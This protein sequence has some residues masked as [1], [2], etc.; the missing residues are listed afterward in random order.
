VAEL[1][2]EDRKRA[3]LQELLHKYVEY[4][5]INLSPDAFDDFIEFCSVPDDVIKGSA[6]TSSWCTSSG[7]TNCIRAWG[8]HVSTNGPSDDRAE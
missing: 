1:E 7:S 3:I 2:N 5:I 8:P 6:S 4:D